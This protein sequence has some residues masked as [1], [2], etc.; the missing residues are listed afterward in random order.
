MAL[1]GHLLDGTRQADVTLD[2]ANLEAAHARDEFFWLDVRQP[3]E[4]ELDLLGEV[5]GF[6]ELA[7]E[8]SRHFGQRA[9]LEEYDDHV[10]LVVYGWTPDEDGLVEVHCYYSD[11]FL[12]T[13]RRDDAPAFEDVREQCQNKLARGSDGIL[14]LHQVVDGLVDSF[15]P[16]LERFDERLEVIEN[17]MLERPS[18]KQVHEILKM[19]RRLT[20]LRKAVGPQRDLFGRLLNGIEVLPGMTRDAE[21]YFRDVYDHLYRLSETMDAYRELMSSAVDVYLSAASNR[22]GSTTKQLA[23]IATIFLP[24]TFVTGFF[25]QN[26]GWMVENV[27]GW[28]EFVVLGIG[29]QFVTI[30]LLVA[31]FKRQGWF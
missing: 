21:R 18:D 16:V 14:V 4:D 8:D 24:L 6:H 11:R 25:G 17:E 23:V 1:A 22:L 9:K 3:S 31:Y 15:L 30:A 12:V 2:R 27:G 10:L 26:F 19:R 5:F 7:L 20:S 13:I 28:R 29:L